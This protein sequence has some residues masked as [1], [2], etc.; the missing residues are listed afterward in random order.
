[1]ED[2]SVAQVLKASWQ[3]SLALAREHP[4][5]RISVEFVQPSLFGAAFTSQIAWDPYALETAK[6][7]ALH[8]SALLVSST[9]SRLVHGRNRPPEIESAIHEVTATMSNPLALVAL[10]SFAPVFPG[11]FRDLIWGSYVT[12]THGWRMKC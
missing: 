3:G 9:A 7:M 10:N 6:Q 4:S 1:M 2:M 5:Q 12:R 11:R 8:L